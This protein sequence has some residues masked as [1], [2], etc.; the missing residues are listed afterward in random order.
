MFKLSTE[1]AMNIL[2]FIGTPKN[3][4]KVPQRS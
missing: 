1:D 3:D 4:A 2:G